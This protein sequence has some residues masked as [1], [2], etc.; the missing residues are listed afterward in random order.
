MKTIKIIILLLLTATAVNSQWIQ[1]TTGTTSPLSD[2]WMFS[3]NNVIVCGN[4]G[5]LLR[6][7]NG[8][9]NWDSIYSSTKT[10]ITEM[11][12]LNATTGWFVNRNDSLFKTVDAGSTW[13]FV[14]IAGDNRTFC[15]VNE[16]TGWMADGNINVRKTTN[17][18]LNWTLVVM[19]HP[20]ITSEVYFSNVNTGFV[21]GVRPSADSTYI[22]KTTNGGTNWNVLLAS[23]RYYNQPFFRDENHIYMC[24]ADGKF[25]ST[26]NGGVSWERKDVA[27]TFDDLQTVVFADDMNGYMAGDES[28]VYSTT[29]G[30][31]NW[32]G[33]T[34]SVFTFFTDITFLPGNSQVGY[35]VGDYGVIY[36]TTNGGPIGINQISNEV[37]SKFM[38][39]Q[40]YPN[41]F[42]PVTNIK[43]SIPKAGNVKL[44]VFDITGREVAELVNQNLKAGT[45]NYDFDASHLASG[46]YFYRLTGEGFSEVKKMILIK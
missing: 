24:G 23:S 1:Q 41:P 25:E 43:F 10:N 44:A 32:Q 40:N 2:A 13:S 6:T 8:G 37:P 15:F 11:F 3:E 7:T 19:P 21:F 16:T 30:G 9:T 5:L 20:V 4:N 42:N 31:V 45:F 38:L 35:V 14:K 18:G 39:E 27:N 17:G 12:F 46:M 22:F 26:T 33:Q 29:N 28:V 34:L 36:K